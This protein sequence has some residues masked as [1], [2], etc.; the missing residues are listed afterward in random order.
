MIHKCRVCLSETQKIAPSRVKARNWIC[1]VCVNKILQKDPAI[2]LAKKLA[3]T[4][5][6]KGIKAPYPGTNFARLVIA[7]CHGK[8]VFSNE[9]DVKKLCIAKEDPNG[10]WTVENA[11]LVT[12]S[13]SYTL[14][15]LDASSDE[16]R[17]QAIR[18]R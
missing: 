2:Y 1:S 10:P 13:E 18:L 6:K 5:R 3:S 8:S 9:S 11:I 14:T 12:S 17:K 16:L 7:K 15:R 4:L